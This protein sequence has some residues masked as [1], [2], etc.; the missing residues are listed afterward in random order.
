VEAAHI[1]SHRYKGRDDIFNGIALCR[2]HHWAFDVGW[3]TIMDNF[4]IQAS[5][6]IRHVPAGFGKIEEY[7]FLLALTNKNHEMRFPDRSEIRPH[8]NAIRWHRQ[9]IFHQ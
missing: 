7:D 3:F 9:N 6:Q 2:F 1:V 5:A 4:T 8:Q